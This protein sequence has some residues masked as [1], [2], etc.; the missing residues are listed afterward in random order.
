MAAEHALEAE[1]DSPISTGAGDEVSEEEPSMRADFS[2]LYEGQTGGI[3]GAGPRLWADPVVAKSLE[4][5]G[6]NWQR[7][8]IGFGAFLKDNNW[9]LQPLGA[10]K[11]FHQRASLDTPGLE[12]ERSEVPVLLADDYAIFAWPPDKADTILTELGAALGGDPLRAPP[13]QGTTQGPRSREFRSR[14]R[15]SH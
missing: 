4:S 6:E 1:E 5:S 7:S 14:P 12:Q 3:S 2:I 15:S 11:E 10:T 9:L 13:P 8:A